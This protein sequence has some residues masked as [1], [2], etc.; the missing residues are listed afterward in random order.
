MKPNENTR[1]IRAANAAL[2]G[3]RPSG[4]ALIPK[5][6]RCTCAHEFQDAVYGKGMRVLNRKRPSP[7]VA[8][9]YVCTVCSA[10]HMGRSAAQATPVAA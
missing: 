1:A 6:D 10:V 9:R 5:I 2:A 3:V 7:K 8:D 4:T